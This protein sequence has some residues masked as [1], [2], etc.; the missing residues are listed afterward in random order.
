MK[1]ILF[2]LCLLPN[3]V[4]AS[5]SFHVPVGLTSLSFH[6]L[7]YQRHPGVGHLIIPEITFYKK[8]ISAVD[9]TNGLFDSLDPSFSAGAIFTVTEL[10][11]FTAVEVGLRVN[12]LYGV[13]G[14]YSKTELGDM[15]S[16]SIY[17]MKNSFLFKKDHIRLYVSF[18][19]SIDEAS[20]IL[21]SKDSFFKGV[22]GLMDLEEDISAGFSYQHNVLSNYG[23]V[24]EASRTSQSIGVMVIK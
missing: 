4:L 24:V 21:K 7:Y 22:R 10:N 6:K 11:L 15:L 3:L 14:K 19:K 5:Q 1:N 2:L 17:F 9:F 12:H 18:S 13:S 16:A 20:D 8:N 23:I